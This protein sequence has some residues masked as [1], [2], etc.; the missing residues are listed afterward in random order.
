[1]QVRH[2]LAPWQVKIA[3]NPFFY[4]GTYLV[5]VDFFN[6]WNHRMFHQVGFLWEI[7][8]FHHAATE[9]TVLTATRDHPV[10]RIFGTLFVVLPVA[11]LA[12]PSG[13]IFWLTLFV[14]AIGP[15]KHSGLDWGW[16]WFGKYVVQSPRAHW[17]HHSTEYRH[18]NKNYASIFSFWDHIFGTWH[19]P[20]KERPVIG[21]ANNPLN[22]RGTL[23]DIWACYRSSCESLWRKILGKDIVRTPAP[24][25][26]I[27]KFELHVD[28]KSSLGSQTKDQVAPAELQSNWRV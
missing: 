13:E 12:P 19:E 11:L 7:H 1:L 5:L 22:R 21:L 25:V 15:I 18:H 9:M 24:R 28:A 27:Y 26:P 20:E 23:W 8:K 14:A 17:I 6:Y 10:E 4:Y 2:S 3:F 16:S